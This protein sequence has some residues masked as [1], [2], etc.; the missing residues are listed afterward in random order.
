MKARIVQ[1]DDIPSSMLEL[2]EYLN[3]QP[4]SSET[5]PR[6]SPE[7]EEEL[8]KEYPMLRSLHDKTSVKLHSGKIFT[9]N[10]GSRAF[11]RL[12]HLLKP[13]YPNPYWLAAISLSVYFL[14]RWCI[15]TIRSQYTISQII[16]TVLTVESFLV[17]VVAVA[18][19]LLFTSFVVTAQKDKPSIDCITRM[20]VM[21]SLSV[22]LLAPVAGTASTGNITLALNCGIIVRGGMLTPALWY[23]EDLCDE[24][25]FGI[26]VL[27]DLFRWWRLLVTATVLIPGIIIRVL[28]LN[29]TLPFKDAFHSNAD[30]LRRR[31]GSRFPTA[32]SLFNDPRGLYFLSA[33]FLMAAGSY[34]IYLI[35]FAVDFFKVRDHRKSKT[36]L[37]KL[38]VSKGIF[39]P[40]VHPEEI[41]GK[42]SAEDPSQAYL[43]APAM[44]LKSQDR[45]FD[46]DSRFLATEDSLPIFTLLDK[47]EEILRKEGAKEWIKPRDEQLPVTENYSEEQRAMDGL[48]NWARPMEASEADQ[49]FEEFFETI[50]ESQYGY[51]P[52]SEEWVVKNSD[53]FQRQSSEPQSEFEDGAE[54]Q[55][56]DDNLSR[57]A[58][59][60]EMQP[61]L[62]KYIQDFDRKS[63]NDDDDDDDSVVFV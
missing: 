28:G 19:P 46:P 61:F 59:S 4:E 32:C 11:S 34:L 40:D 41:K 29:N 37:S 62:K 25:K 20:L 16:A 5:V 27:F 9:Y 18:V 8:F 13:R 22:L 63:R 56:I 51:D 14:A 10:D 54:E 50:D 26:T 57:F 55:R 33:I 12:Y 15:R 60:P 17:C 3:Q 38:F 53:L 58:T 49:S 31:I 21:Y 52:D 42:L 45:L 2:D 43:P 7:D 39:Q 44:L 47:E 6:L 30:L 1:D 23:W 24:H 48:A 36:V 35:V